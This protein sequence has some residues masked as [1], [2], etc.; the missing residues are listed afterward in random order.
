GQD[1]R[2]S[3]EWEKKFEALKQT[4]IRTENLQTFVH[5]LWLSIKKMLLEN[6]ENNDSILREYL[7]KNIHKLSESLS[8]DHE[9]AQRINRWVRHFAYRMILKNRSEVEKLISSTVS[10]WEGKEFSRKLELE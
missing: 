6:M 9:L 4:L 3:E 5:D 10:A 2:T 7:N 8:D 1:L